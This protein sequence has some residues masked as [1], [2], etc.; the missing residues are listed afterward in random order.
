MKIAPGT[1]ICL[2]MNT[3]QTPP[4]PPLPSLSLPPPLSLG[5]SPHFL[6]LCLSP[7]LSGTGVWSQLCSSMP[8]PLFFL[9]CFYAELKAIMCLQRV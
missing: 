7:P 6:S 3:F 5:L 8:P 4:P 1:F 9:E 2:Y